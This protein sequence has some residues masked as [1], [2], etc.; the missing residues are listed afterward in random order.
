MNEFIHLLV[1]DLLNQPAI[2][3]GLVTVLG[4]SLGKHSF[5]KVLEGGSKW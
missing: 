1:F 2:F 3:L 4:L 5:A